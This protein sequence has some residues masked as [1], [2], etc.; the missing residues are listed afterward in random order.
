MSGRAR[1]RPVGGGGATDDERIQQS[2]NPLFSQWLRDWW[3][4]YS[5]PAYQ[6]PTNERLG[7]IYKKVSIAFVLKYASNP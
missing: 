2:A 4:E 3:K 7:F 5:T 6:N 1:R